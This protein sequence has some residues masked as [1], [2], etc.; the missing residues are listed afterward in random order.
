MLL[1][2]FTDSSQSVATDYNVSKY[3]FRYHYLDGSGDYFNGYFYAPSFLYNEG[4]T[5]YLKDETNGNNYG[6]YY[7]SIIT[8]GYSSDYSGREVISSYYDADTKKT[9]YTLYDKIGQTTANHHLNMANVFAVESGYVYD[10]SI[11]PT[12]AYFGN[13]DVCYYFTPRQSVN[14]L[15][16]YI[17]DLP[18]WSQPKTLYGSCAAVGGAIILS[19]WDR[20]EFENLIPTDWQ[21][22]WPDNTADIPSYVTL[23]SELVQDMNW[24]ATAEDI[25]AGFKKYTSLHGYK[26]FVV[27]F[28]PVDENRTAYWYRF[29]NALDSGRPASLGGASKEV[30]HGFVGR[31][32]WN[33]GHI[34]ANMGLGTSFLNY[35]LDWNQT[36]V[37]ESYSSLKIDAFYDFFYRSRAPLVPVFHLL[38]DD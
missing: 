15:A 12:D 35:R 6:Y 8:N 4:A 30:H 37:G 29:K 10:P 33:D 34:V 26:N 28:Y 24:G 2:F 31:G 3:N 7:I 11:P 23:I 22:L 14:F 16:A 32:Y 18:Y 5:I 21:N 38:L 25:V 19:H 36:Y 17:A 20:N 13:R 9:S 27:V 1:V